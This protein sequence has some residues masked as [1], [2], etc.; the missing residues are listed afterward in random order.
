MIVPTGGNKLARCLLGNWQWNLV[1][2]DH[3]PSA[4]FRYRG[5]QVNDNAASA[6]RLAVSDSGYRG[7]SRVMEPRDQSLQVRRILP[8]D[9]YVALGEPL[10]DGAWAV[11][12][13]IKPYVR[14]IWLG[15][16]MMGLGGLLAAFDPRYRVKVRSRVRDVLG[17]KEAAA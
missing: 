2:T 4:G 3:S 7:L 10:G 17:M 13:H 12:V 14:W 9:L 6:P 8:G 11:R 1:S 15:G 16:L 5:K